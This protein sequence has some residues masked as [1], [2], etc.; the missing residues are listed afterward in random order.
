MEKSSYIF[1]I[2]KDFRQIK[3]ERCVLMSWDY[4]DL[5]HTAKEAGGPEKYIKDLET[6]NY[7][8]GFKDGKSE[9]VTLDLAVAGILVGVYTLCKYIRNRIKKKATPEITATQAEYA[10][11]ELIKGIVNADVS[12][13]AN[14]ETPGESIENEEEIENGETT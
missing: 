7:N 6:F 5:S 10:R 4:S 9:Q 3:N 8:N 2:P 13:K 11:E 12:G 14:D 1:C